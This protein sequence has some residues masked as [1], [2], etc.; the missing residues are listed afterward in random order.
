MAKKN[1]FDNEKIYEE[2][3]TT[4][5]LDAPRE[6]V[7]NYW[8]DPKLLVKWA[9]F[10]DF[11][12]PVCT[13]DFRVN[14]RYFIDLRSPEGRHF[15]CTGVYREIIDRKQIICTTSFTDEQGNVVSAVYYGL[16]RDFPAEML[17]T[18]TFDDRDGKTLMTLRHDGLPPGSM[19]DLIREGWSRSFDKLTTRISEKYKRA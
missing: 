1:N 2:I 6:L 15:R 9:G 10:Q 8:I 4:R 11:A 18:M 12:S 13:I 19:T 5:M 7:W 17:V 16:S 3:V 14:G